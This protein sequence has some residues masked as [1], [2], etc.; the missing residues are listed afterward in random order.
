MVHHDRYDPSLYMS[1]EDAYNYLR[2]LRG[3][4]LPKYKSSEVDVTG[5]EAA[6]RDE[7]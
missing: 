6:A 1:N 5:Q 3:A 4:T 7:K 2:R